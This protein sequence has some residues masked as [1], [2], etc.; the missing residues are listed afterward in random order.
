MKEDFVHEM[1]IN[2][3]VERE[4]ERGDEE[5]YNTAALLVHGIM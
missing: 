3:L 5:Q 2:H 4:R 1:E